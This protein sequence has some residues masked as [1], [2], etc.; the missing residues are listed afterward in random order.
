M[1]FVGQKYLDQKYLGVDEHATYTQQFFEKD[2]TFFRDFG[3]NLNFNL[4]QKFSMVGAPFF[5]Q[6]IPVFLKNTS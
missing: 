1:F 4:H 3:K 2:R 6:G 5:L